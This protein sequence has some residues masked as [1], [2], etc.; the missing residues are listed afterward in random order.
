MQLLWTR[1]PSCLTGDMHDHPD[2][3][4][5]ITGVGGQKPGGTA[6]SPALA[7]DLRLVLVKMELSLW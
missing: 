7:S 3:E 4:S 1:V 5:G 6:G 2:R